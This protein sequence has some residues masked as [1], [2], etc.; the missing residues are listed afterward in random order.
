[1]K[2]SSRV[3]VLPLAALLAWGLAAV[4]CSKPAPP[5]AAPSKPAAAEQ[6]KPA[7]P[8]AAP[9]EPEPAPAPRPEPTT[10]PGPP[11]P[12]PK[13][14][15]TS[16]AEPV[17]GGPDMAALIETLTTTDDSRTR[18]I[19]IDAI[20][21]ELRDGLPA[22]DALVKAL[23]DEEPRVRWHAARAIGLIGHEAAP[24]IANLVKLLDDADAIT[25]TQAA[26]AIG[27]IREDDER[28]EIPPADQQAYAAAVDPLVKTLVHPDARARR[29]SIR[30]LRHLAASREDLL[31]TVRLQLADADPQRLEIDYGPFER[32][33][34]LPP[35]SDGEHL[36]AHLRHGLLT[37]HVP[38]RASARPVTVRV[39]PNGDSTN[40]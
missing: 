39:L 38:R 33:D 3:A 16:A 32:V 7:Q 28:S 24:A 19:A 15:D 18:V 30:A 29:A 37:V 31:K 36:T 11:T 13:P 8:P 17:D 12:E 4:G 21:A 5:P 23:A 26:A 9:A 35:D 27:H 6:P 1:M 34:A 22:L 40:E 25:V 10:P 2:P 20:A 14:A